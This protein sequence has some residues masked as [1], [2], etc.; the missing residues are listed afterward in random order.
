[1]TQEDPGSL[2]RIC[3]ESG[4]EIKPVYEASDVERTGGRDNIGKPGQ[5]PFTR[6]IHKDM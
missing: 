1:M 4:I 2:G 5:F 3:N 6:G